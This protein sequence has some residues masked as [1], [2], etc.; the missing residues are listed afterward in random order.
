MVRTKAISRLDPHPNQKDR[1]EFKR[2]AP[3]IPPPSPNADVDLVV[4]MMNGTTVI[5][6]AT[7]VV[8]GDW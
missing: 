5:A 6:V 8:S 3:G 2:G 4:V 7:G 1:D